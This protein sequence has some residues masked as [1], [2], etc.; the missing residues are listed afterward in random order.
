MAVTVRPLLPERHAAWDAFVLQ[1]PHGT[2]F[3]LTAWMQCI[4][5]TFGYTP[6]YLLAENAG[7]IRGLLPL[8]LVKNFVV[9]KALISTP[10]AVYG[11]ILADAPEVRESLLAHAA[12]LGR[13][14]DAEYVELRNSDVEQR[15]GLPPVERYA[16]FTCETTPDEDQLL[17]NLPK[18]TRNVVR[19]ALKQPFTFR[20][21]RDCA[22][23]EDLHAR[24]L[25]RLGTPSFPPQHFKTLLK[26]F[27]E[28][29][30]IREVLCDQRVVAASLNFYFRDQMHVYYAATDPRYQALCANSFLYFQMLCWAGKNGFRTFDFGRSKK[31]TGAFDFKR[32]WDTTQH[33]L[34]YEVLLV[35]RKDVPNFSP[36]NPKFQA[37]IRVWK[38]LPLSVTR[39]L[40]P[41]VVRLFP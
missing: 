13:S 6:V 37:A 38:S 35:K 23:F 14:V 36:A 7:T 12:S 19:K 11:G 16:T 41:R 21:T 17:G 15:L 27:G 24:N 22:A 30:D 39:L 32:R 10:F 2:P 33:E 3:H 20:Q 28:A 40:G 8:F 29:V 4:E 25:H 26:V 9:G 34:P 18:K 1:H 31:E 5:Q